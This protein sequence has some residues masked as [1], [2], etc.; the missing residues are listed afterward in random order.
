VAENAVRLV[1]AG[2]LRE[3]EQIK[4]DTLCLHG[5][6]PGAVNNARQIR[7]ALE[8]AGVAIRSLA[9]NG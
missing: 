8:A 7:S 2:I 1:T 4:I 9:A 6:H 5:D 3:G